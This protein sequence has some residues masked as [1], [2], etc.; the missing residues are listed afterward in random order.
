MQE[1]VEN[2]AQKLELIQKEQVKLV[3]L[4][5]I[6]E[7]YFERADKPGH[8]VTIRVPITELFENVVRDAARKLNFRNTQVGVLGGSTPISFVGKSVGDVIKEASSVSFQ[9][10]SAEMLG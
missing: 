10:A 1:G 6:V 5:H 9:I 4:P 2:R 7:L 8:G 3:E